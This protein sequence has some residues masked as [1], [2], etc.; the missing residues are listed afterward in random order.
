MSVFFINTA[1]VGWPSCQ[2]A[3]EMTTRYWM[4]E[5]YYYLI[6]YLFFF[7]MILVVLNPIVPGCFD[8]CAILATRNKTENEKKNAWYAFAVRSR[9]LCSEVC[10]WFVQGC[11]ETKQSKTWVSFLPVWHHVSTV[12]LTGGLLAIWT[13]WGPGSP[14]LSP[15]FV[16]KIP[17]SWWTL[18]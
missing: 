18:N 14:V 10:G 15:P 3:G 9:L 6:I 7:Y 11:S 8:R 13:E 17:P 4:W 12:H 5:L 2:L 16:F 1:V